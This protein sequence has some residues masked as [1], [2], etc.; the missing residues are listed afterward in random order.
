MGWEEIPLNMEN[1]TRYLN[2]KV[3]NA[4]ETICDAGLL[5]PQPVIVRNADVVH[6]F[7]ECVFPGK[8]QVVQAFRARLFHAFQTEP[9]I[10][11][12]FL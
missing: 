4:P 12:N 10:D 1:S 9:D 5:L 6:I 2:E 3:A 7:E 11:W 8:N